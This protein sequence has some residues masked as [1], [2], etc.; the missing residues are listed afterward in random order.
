MRKTLEQAKNPIREYE[1]KG[2][3]PQRLSPSARQSYYGNEK[4]V[5]VQPASTS[6]KTLPAKVD[7]KEKKPEEVRNRSRQSVSPMDTNTNMRHRVPEASRSF[8][9]ENTE[10]KS[11]SKPRV[12]VVP[13]GPSI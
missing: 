12:E 1:R 7:N 8:G 11:T 3:S 10:T 13:T 2:G 4:T 5:P 9:K 6:S